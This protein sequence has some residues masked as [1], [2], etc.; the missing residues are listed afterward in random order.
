MAKKDYYEILGVSKNA[1]V[2]EIIAAYKK[3]A[4][5]YHPDRQQGKSEAEKKEAEEKFKECSEAAEVLRDPDKRQKYDQFGDADFQGGFDFG[6]GGFDPMEFFRQMHGGP[7]GFGFFGDFGFGDGFGRRG[8]GMAAPARDPNAPED[9]DSYETGISVSFKESIFG[10]KKEITLDVGE[11]CPDC[12]GTGCEKGTTA[13]TCPN[14]G[15]TGQVSKVTR[16]GMMVHRV[17][18]G[19]PH[20][21]GSGV[22]FK[23]CR[24][25]GGSKRIAKE[26]HVTVT[27]PAGAADGT[28]LRLA[29]CGQCG[30]KGGRPGDVYVVLRTGSSP[31]FDRVGNDIYFTAHVPATTA[32]LG[33]KVKIPTLY[34]YR[35]V[36]IEPGT[37]AGAKLKVA[38]YGVKTAAGT[39]SMVITV[40]PETP[41]SMS[42]DMKKALEKAQKLESPGNYAAMSAAMKAAENFYS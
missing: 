16:T 42:A 37:Q 5:L 11:E 41:S 3:K 18:S 12:K 26:R 38:G 39:G 35:D 21:R 4:M 22:V 8:G 7:D 24:K 9:G 28:R 17:I 29:G 20:C 25:C 33:G 2:E 31:I 14:C 13:S 10:C 30:V 15:G 32:A 1:T 6:G 19:C 27:I 23:P 40:V 34:G 36:K